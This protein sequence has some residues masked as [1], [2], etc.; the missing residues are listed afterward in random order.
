L[1]KSP[2]TRVAP[3][4]TLARGMR[5]TMRNWW[6]IGPLGWIVMP[7]RMPPQGG[8]LKYP[9]A[10]HVVTVRL[11]DGWTLRCRVNEIFAVAEVFAVGTYDRPNIHWSEAR[12]ILDIGANVGAATLWMARRAPNARIVAVEPSPQA[13]E[14]LRD[15]VRRNGLENRVT[16]VAGGVG[17][18]AGITHIALDGVSVSG[19]TSENETGAEVQ[20]YTLD[21]VAKVAGTNGVDVIKID[22]EGAEY[23]AFAG[24]SPELLRNVEAVVGEYHAVPGHDRGELT[25]LL[26]PAGFEV[27]LKGDSDLGSLTALRPSAQ[28]A[29]R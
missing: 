24:A 18:A 3:V 14:L 21:D 1:T 22:C 27:T 10:R 17:R 12:T 5:S 15:N 4:G 9:I 26:R 6:Y 16:V 11:R 29:Q 20:V 13:L 19:R 28:P 2:K 23:D 8:L 25:E 7:S